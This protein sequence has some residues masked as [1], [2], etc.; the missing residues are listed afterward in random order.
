MINVPQYE[1]LSLDHI[2]DFG[3]GYPAVENALPVLREIRKMPRSYICSVIYTLVGT[4]FKTWVDTRCNDRNHELALKQDLLI[5]LDEKVA[6]AF[7]SST[8]I[9]RKLNSFFASSMQPF[10]NLCFPM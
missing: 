7:L 2:L 4:P 9:S 10:I 8:N 1:S 5:K 3:L 6:K